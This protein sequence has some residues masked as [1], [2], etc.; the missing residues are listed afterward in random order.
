MGQ[1]VVEKQPLK[2]AQVNTAT[3]SKIPP[4]EEVEKKS[5]WQ[6]LTQPH[7]KVTDIEQRRR[8][9]FLAASLIFLIPVAIVGLLVS[10]ITTPPTTET[11]RLIVIGMFVVV[12]GLI[13]I[14][15]LSRTQYYS[16]GA[17]AVIIILFAGAIGLSLLDPGDAVTLIPFLSL[18]ALVTS[19][20]FS[21]QTTLIA[22]IFANV[23]GI[24]ALYT[25][26]QALN[27]AEQD[28]ITFNIIMGVLIVAA[29]F[30]RTQYIE[31]IELQATQLDAARTTLEQRVEDR[32]RQLREANEELRRFAYI[33]SHDL[34][35]HLV[36]FSGFTEELNTSV[37]IVRDTINDLI[38]QSSAEVQDEMGEVLNEDIPDF[39]SIIDT[40]VAQMKRMVDAMLEL[41]R[42]ENRTLKLELLNM[43]ALV[44]DVLTSLSTEIKT[45]D[46]NVKTESLP[47]AIADRFAMERVFT[48]LIHNAVIYSDESRKSEI[49]IGGEVTN[50]E[51][52]FF[53]QDNGIGV[54]ED[55][56]QEIFDIFKRVGESSASGDGMGL[57][58]VRN[59]VQRHNGTVKCDS[60]RGLGSKFTFTIRHDLN[61]DMGN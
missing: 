8:A 44:S 30:I 60:I 6:K 52:S 15:F 47:D 3:W 1:H 5:L 59:L 32:T 31:R 29:A 12:F 42:L 61:S 18:V 48:N 4:S 38:S 36:N 24:V 53:V 19:L 45:Y 22:A 9:Q 40:S 55:N 33:L 2:R 35:N 54:H 51:T 16:F 25:P 20:L 7:S 50:D 39:L 17:S 28:I 56:L 27:G 58:F 26:D 43:D 57:A 13:G 37:D 11:G 23:A 10:N 41:A 14:Y 49:T 46:V 21:A 34:R